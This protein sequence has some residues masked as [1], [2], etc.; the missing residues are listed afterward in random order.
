[1]GAVAETWRKGLTA[2]NTEGYVFLVALYGCETWSLNK[3]LN[4]KVLVCAWF[5]PRFR[6]RL[7]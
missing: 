6:Y 4:S 5:E 2:V 3:W 1:M 7:M